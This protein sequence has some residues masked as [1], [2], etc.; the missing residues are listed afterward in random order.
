VHEL[1][2]CDDLL[3]QVNT[4]AREHNASS[5]NSITVKIGPLSGVESTLL[6]SAFAMMRE[7]TV[8]EHA[9]LLVQLSSVEVC[10]RRCGKQSKTVANHLICHT[11]GSSETTLISGDELILASVDM[12]CAA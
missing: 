3:S 9:R 6:E 5:V 2:L 12:N 4:I 1:S 7:G 8:A 11:C 10:C